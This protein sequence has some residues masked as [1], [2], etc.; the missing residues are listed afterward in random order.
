M[1]QEIW[2]HLG[3]WKERKRIH[4]HY[5]SFECHEEKATCYTSACQ[6]T[7]SY[8]LTTS[9][10]YSGIPIFT[11]L[12][13]K[14]KLARKTGAFEKSGIKLRCSSQEG[15]LL[16]IRGIGRFEKLRV[17][18][19]NRD[20]TVAFIGVDISSGGSRPWA[21]KGGSSCLPCRFFFLASFFFYPK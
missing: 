4:Y 15:K 8:K 7:P 18:L 5:W 19:R 16:L 21:K 10:L 13:G 1:D 14:R 17:R 11:N 6:I 20:S 12:Q 3:S 9:L 2:V